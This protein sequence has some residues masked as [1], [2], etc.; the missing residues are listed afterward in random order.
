MFETVITPLFHNAVINLY[1]MLG[2]YVQLPTQLTDISNADS[3][4]KGIPQV[5][6]L[7]VQIRKRFIGNIGCGQSRKK[8]SSVGAVKIQ[9]RIGGGHVCDKD[10]LL[11]RNVSMHPHINMTVG[12]VRANHHKALSG[13]SSY[14]EIGL[15]A[16]GTISPLGI[17]NAPRGHRNVVTA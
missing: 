3:P 6:L 2:W 1:R 16:P 7:C 8:G 4:N 15:N 5:N 13:Q 11:I 12:S 9:L 14:R 17:H 10:V